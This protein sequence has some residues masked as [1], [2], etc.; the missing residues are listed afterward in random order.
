MRKI[1][2]VALLLSL[3]FS[4]GEKNAMIITKYDQ[5]TNWNVAR[6][7]TECGL[8]CQECRRFD[9]SDYPGYSVKNV[10]GNPFNLKIA[11][12]YVFVSV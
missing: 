6:I 2:A 12:T 1:L 7:A 11:N 9:K 5:F 4:T 8:L 10:A 3:V